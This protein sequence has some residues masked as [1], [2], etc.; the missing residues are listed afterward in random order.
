MPNERLVQLG[1]VQ[2]V[3]ALQS[4]RRKKQFRWDLSFIFNI[5]KLPQK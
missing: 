1:I 2:N 5:N 4:Y 3:D